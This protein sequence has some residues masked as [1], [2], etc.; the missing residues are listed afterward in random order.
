MKL[1]VS[2]DKNGEIL[3]LFD[4]ESLHGEKGSLQY[5]PKPG[6]NYQIISVGK[7]LES[8]TLLEIHK[9]M[10]VVTGGDAEPKLE[11]LITPKSD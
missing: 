5:S 8:S 1:G 10:R 9:T 6:E 4:S 7:E 3:G 11:R 2:Y